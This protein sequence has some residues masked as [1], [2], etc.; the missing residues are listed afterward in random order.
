MTAAEHRRTKI[1]LMVGSANTSVER[2]FQGA[3]PAN[4]S[5][6]GARMALTGGN[7]E[8]I[9]KMD[10]DIDGCAARLGSAAVDIIVF[11]STA[12]SLLGKSGGGPGYDV[13][14]SRRI[15]DQA[16][17]IATL[18]TSTAVL[19]ALAALGLA[20]LSLVTPYRDDVTDLI[21][22]FL[23]ANGHAVV[24]RAGRGLTSTRAFGDDSLKEIVRFVGANVSD[25]A[26]GVFLSCTN[27]RAMDAAQQLEEAIGKPVVTSN[28]AT[29][30]ATL[31]RL[32]LTAGP[33]YGRLMDVSAQA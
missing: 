9:R 8:A 3:V 17:G 19:E 32:G 16:G 30:W 22:D 24:S 31:G 1:G 18:A 33:G 6:H 13:R 2:D 4:V 28:Q 10:A 5:L 25:D 11:G 21:A 20:R 26:D 15:K 27:W 29:V 12:G 7:A 14:V 23:V